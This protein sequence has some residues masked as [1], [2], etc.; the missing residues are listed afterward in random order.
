[1][2]RSIVI[3]DK[4]SINFVLIDPR[5]ISV[6]NLW[7]TGWN[8]HMFLKLVKRNFSGRT[9]YPAAFTILFRRKD[10]GLYLISPIKKSK[11]V[12]SKHGGQRDE[13]RE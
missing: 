3:S 1:M 7:I 10:C 12:E 9:S 2:I 13:K 6:L 11:M 4:G 5:S 8:I